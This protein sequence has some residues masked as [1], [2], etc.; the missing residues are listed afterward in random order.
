M[1]GFIGRER[2][3]ALLASS[4]ERVTAG[5]RAGRPGRAILMRGRRRVGKSRLAEEFVERAAVPHLFFTASAQSGLAA[6]LRLFVEAGQSSDLPMASVFRDQTPTSWD[7]AL[8]LLAAA[9]PPV[10]CRCRRA[11]LPDR[12][13]PGIRGV[14]TEGVRP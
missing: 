2:E 1:A 13:R 12:Q 5:G 8:R 10:H 9:L 7:A 3:L 4:L 6:D 11:A 14:A